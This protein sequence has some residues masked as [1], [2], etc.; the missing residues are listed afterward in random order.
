L[1][2]EAIRKE[3]RKCTI[4]I[5][6]GF[7]HKFITN[8]TDIN[9]IHLYHPFLKIYMQGLTMMLLLI[10]SSY[11]KSLYRSSVNKMS[12]V[13]TTLYR[14]F[15]FL[16]LKLVDAL[17]RSVTGNLISVSFSTWPD[18]MLKIFWL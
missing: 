15:Y 11:N 4:S 12:L 10:C 16:R 6:M 17:S 2:R 14:S 8:H 1:G 9:R 18:I 5:T 13:Y 7:P 3:H